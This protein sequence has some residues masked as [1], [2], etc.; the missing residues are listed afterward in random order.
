MLEI[1]VYDCNNISL[2]FNLLSYPTENVVFYENGEYFEQFFGKKTASKLV[3][4][5]QR[6]CETSYS[7][8]YFGAAWPA[9]LITKTLYRLSDEVM[10]LLP[11]CGVVL[12]RERKLA[13]ERRGV[14]THYA[15]TSYKSSKNE[16]NS[17]L[18]YKLN[19][20]QEHRFMLRNSTLL[21]RTMPRFLIWQEFRHFSSIAQAK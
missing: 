2:L 15:R 18:L 7:G 13:S 9:S 11:P 4:I 3:C 1:I 17:V 8:W 21:T 6:K 5:K 10:S 12:G 19:V 20:L 14:D 16:T